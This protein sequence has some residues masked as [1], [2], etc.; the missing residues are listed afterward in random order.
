MAPPL[1]RAP[2][3]NPA[4]SVAGPEILTGSAAAIGHRRRLRRRCWLKPS[5]SDRALSE[6]LVR[7]LGFELPEVDFLLDAAA[8]LDCIWICGVQSDHAP[9]LAALRL[10]HPGARIVLTGRDLT[11]TDSASLLAAGADC[12]LPWPCPVPVLRAA[13]TG[14]GEGG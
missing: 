11:P 13:L 12:V 1:G 3:D 6:L 10:E 14:E 7:Q 5:R 4:A 2:A 9:D 8:D